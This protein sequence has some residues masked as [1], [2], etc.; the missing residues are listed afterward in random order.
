VVSLR[1]LI[2]AIDVFWQSLEV[3]YSHG[4]KASSCGLFGAQMVQAMLGDGQLVCDAT[5]RHHGWV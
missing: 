2:I 4:Y 5:T 1:E 3:G